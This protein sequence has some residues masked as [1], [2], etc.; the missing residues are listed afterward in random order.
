MSVYFSKSSSIIIPVG[1][2]TWR[3]SLPVYSFPHMN[4]ILLFCRALAQRQDLKTWETANY[5][6]LRTARSI[7]FKLKMQM[8]GYRRSYV[9]V[10]QNKV[11]LTVDPLTEDYYWLLK[12]VTITVNDLCLYVLLEKKETECATRLS[13]EEE[14]REEKKAETTDVS[15]SLSL[16]SKCGWPC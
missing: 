11:T 6:I 2:F 9:A 12:D 15:H 13:V 5:K 8:Q 10:F 14:K 1:E 4:C 3:I 16:H 7:L